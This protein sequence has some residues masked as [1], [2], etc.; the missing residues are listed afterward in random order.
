MG[1]PY[2]GPNLWGFGGRRPPKYEF[3]GLTPPK[4]TSLHQTAHFKIICV[5]ICRWMQS[6][7][8]SEKKKIVG[9][10]ISHATWQFHVCVA[11]PLFIRSLSNLVNLF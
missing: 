4:G 6:G 11:A 2:S 1:F 3:W 7:E 9:W 10:E 8:R 5:N